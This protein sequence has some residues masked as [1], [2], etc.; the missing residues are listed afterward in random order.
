MVGGTFIRVLAALAL[1]GV[2]IAIGVGVYDAGVTAGLAQQ[3]A[4]VASGAPAVVYGGPYAGHWGWGWGPGFGFFG[5][6]FW[7]LGIFLIFALLRAAFGFGR[8]GRYRGGWGD[9]H[10]RYGYGDPRDHLEDW[11]RQAHEAGSGSSSTGSTGG[12]GESTPRS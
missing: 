2:L 3:G 1:V 8:G 10:G 7:I 4:A 5:I 12:S 6:F 11:H 9:H